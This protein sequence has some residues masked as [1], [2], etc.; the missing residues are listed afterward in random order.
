MTRRFC[1]L[2][3]L[4]YLGLKDFIF[5]VVVECLLYVCVETSA[6]V[7]EREKNAVDLELWVKAIFYD[8]YR[9]YHLGDSNER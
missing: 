8:V 4:R 3:A 5:K 6:I 9:L 1:G 7:V 2:R